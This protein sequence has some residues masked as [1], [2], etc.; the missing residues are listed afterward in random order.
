TRQYVVEATL[1]RAMQRRRAGDGAKAISALKHLAGEGI[2][3]PRWALPCIRELMLAGEWEAANTL[4]EQLPNDNLRAELLTWRVD[5]VLLQGEDSFGYLPGILQAEARAVLHALSELEH[6]RDTAAEAAVAGLRA[7]SPLYDWK[8]LVQGLAAFYQGA[9]A[10]EHWQTLTPSRAPATLAAPFQAQLDP[11]SIAEHPEWDAFVAFGRRHLQDEWLAALEAAKGGIE[12]EEMGHV[13]THAGR[14][15]QAMPSEPQALRDRLARTV[16]WLMAKHGFEEELALYTAVFDPP[17]DDPSLHRLRALMHEQSGDKAE[18]QHAWAAYAAELDHNPMIR[19]ED[20]ALAC[21]LIWF[22][23]GE[24]AE[25]AA[26]PPPMGSFPFFPDFE[27]ETPAFDGVYCYQQS[28]QLAPTLLI[29]HEATIDR[30]HAAGKQPEKVKA[31]RHL[32]THFPEHEQ[33]LVTLADD[34]F[35]RSRWD[36][37]VTFQTRAVNVRPHVDELRATLGF[38]ELGLARLRAQQGQFHEARAMLTAHLEKA[39]P[40]EKTRLLCR[41][42]AVELKAG[43]Q[44]LGESLYEQAQAV[45]LSPLTA[46]FDM[47]VEAVRMPVEAKWIRTV[48]RAFRQELKSEWHSPSACYLLDVVSAFARLNID[49]AAYEQHQKWVFQYLRRGLKL[50]LSEAELCHICNGLKYFAS[51]KL[52]LDYARRGQKE[53]PEHPLFLLS[54]AVHYVTRDPEKCPWD[55]AD[56]LLHTAHDLASTD[57]AHADLM[58]PIDALL[59]VV[60]SAMDMQRLGA[61]TSPTGGAFDVPDEL[62][63]LDALNALQRLFGELLDDDDDDDDDIFDFFNPFG[64]PPGRRRSGSPSRRKKRSRRKR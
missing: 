42:A 7:D 29:A 58:E 36:Q 51:Q 28:A 1:K 37:A 64:P 56:D 33:A 27:D 45:A 2:D 49:Y 53:Y 46:A 30:L 52:F 26:S 43:E 15:A 61:L 55:K 14:A 41:Q 57:P 11:T 9:D 47:L 22:H 12:I 23:M 17:P 8:C 6:G 44:A 63:P 21:G 59:S 3:D 48:E 38:Y 34:A 19:A 62:S 50:P 25:R 54:Q 40:A 35:R 4:S 13:L 60:H 18:A 16:Y 10:L 31:A 20:R 24:I 5:A 39:S 32:L